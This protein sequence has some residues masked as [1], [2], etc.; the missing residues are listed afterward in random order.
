M[1]NIRRGHNYLFLKLITECRRMCGKNH[2]DI[3]RGIG[4]GWLAIPS[5]LSPEGGCSPQQSGFYGHVLENCSEF[6]EPCNGTG[7]AH[8]KQF[9]PYLIVNNLG[10]HY[11]V[12]GSCEARNP[13]IAFL[14]LWKFHVRVRE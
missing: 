3:Q 1:P 9:A 2:V 10:D 12:L 13:S 7:P 11:A 14:Y 5:R 4:R 6:I 8:P